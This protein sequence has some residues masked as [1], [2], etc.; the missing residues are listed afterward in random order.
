LFNV[1]EKI[2]QVAKCLFRMNV[3][4]F[5]L[6]NFCTYEASEKSFNYAQ[7]HAIHCCVYYSYVLLSQQLQFWSIDL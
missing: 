3:R 4:I 6:E 5:N 1:I 2:L 7:N